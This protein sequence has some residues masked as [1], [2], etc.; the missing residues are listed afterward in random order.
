MTICCFTRGRD[1]VGMG[2]LKLILFNF[3]GNLLL[4]HTKKK[5]LTL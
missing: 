3:N 4:V 2:V 5:K 1:G